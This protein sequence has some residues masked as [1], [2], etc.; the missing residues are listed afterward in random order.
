M[1]VDYDGEQAAPA[2]ASAV[3][4][5]FLRRSFS[6]A[7]IFKRAL[8]G[9]L[10]GAIGL[11]LG[12]V[13]GIYSVWIT[14]PSY[15]VTIGL[16]PVD[17]TG[18]DINIGGDTGGALGALAGLI[19]IGGGPVP[20]F[21]RFVASLYSSGV[22]KIMDRDHDMVCLTFGAC[23]PKTHTWR[24]GTGFNAWMARVQASIAHLPDPDSPRTAV[25]LANYTENNVTLTSD[26]TTHV[27]TLTMES[28]DPKSAVVF[29]RNLVQSTN[30]YIKQEDRGNIQ[31]YVDYINRKLATNLNVAQHDALSSLLLEQ[32]RRLMLTSVNVPYAASIQDGPNVSTSNSALRMLAVDGFLGMILGL[33]LGVFR[34]MRSRRSPPRSQP[35]TQS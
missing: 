20:K 35:W 21:T 31:P 2:P 25:D 16:L 5:G 17:S 29:L 19:G 24:K 15:V 10:F 4:A 22:A 3:I 18:G 9:W 14:P 32:E 23:D 34:S 11:V 13:F 12:L 8:R 1:T 6:I 30:D 7:E 28:R 26:R 27:L 33:G